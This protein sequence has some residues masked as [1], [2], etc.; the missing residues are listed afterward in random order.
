MCASI[1]W[2]T[3]QTRVIRPT[4]KNYRIILSS[5]L[6]S[7]FGSKLNVLLSRRAV[8]FCHLKRVFC[9]HKST[10]R[11][12]G[13]GIGKRKFSEVLEIFKV[14]V[15]LEFRPSQIRLG[16]RLNMKSFQKF[17]GL[18]SN[19]LSLFFSL[20]ISHTHTHTH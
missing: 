14:F 3:A 12:E 19:S 6:L 18:F 16:P 15:F 13:K 5:F 2:E 20:S 10:L 4:L 1:F 11:T 7:L 17:N 9:Q 8:T